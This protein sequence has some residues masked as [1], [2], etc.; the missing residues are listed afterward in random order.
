MTPK[1]IKNA[2]EFLYN[3]GREDYAKSNINLRNIV[4]EKYQQRFN[5]AMTKVENASK[6]KV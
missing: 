6:R 4:D 3:L 5:E 1:T 2:R